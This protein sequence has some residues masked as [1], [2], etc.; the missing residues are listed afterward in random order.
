[1]KTF[2]S[3][4]VAL[5][6]A[7]GV[8]P[9]RAQTPADFQQMAN[10]FRT[11][12][13]AKQSDSLYSLYSPQMATALPPDKTAQLLDQLHIQL[14]ML[15][16]IQLSHQE[17][18]YASYKATFEKTIVTMTLAVDS[19]KHLSGFHFLP[20]QPETPAAP[21]NGES[22]ILQLETST[23][24]L[25]GTLVIPPGHSKLPVVLI[26][27]GSGPTDRDGNSP[28]LGLH[29][30]MYK[31]LADSLSRHGIASLRYDKR[32][33][34]A[35]TAAM[36]SEASLTFASYIDDAVG[37]LA[38]LRADPRFS[39]VIV[40]GHSEGSLV[41]MVASEN[42]KADAYISAAGAGDRIDKVLLPQL[43]V[44]SPPLADSARILFDSLAKGQS[45]HVEQG[46]LLVFFRASI[47]P[48][49]I[50]WLRY[51]PQTEI[52]KLHIPVLII[53]GSTDLQTT[54]GDA[55]KMK[56]AK[57]DATLKIITGMNHIFRQVGADR[58]P[59]IATYNDPSLPL[60]PEVVSDIVAFLLTLH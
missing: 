16:T 53:Q 11:L 27:A 5:L 21:V 13:N 59:N 30:D 26:I 39:K 29:S 23:G 2:L 48:Y 40:L 44:Q 56:A 22:S 41:G 7:A 43:A 14:G 45:V 28:M 6:F 38:L 50:S 52:K 37:Y 35:S 10:R 8:L 49:M 33:V 19:A 20:Y 24:T 3:L 1:M 17:K 57:P 36:S 42:G 32:G 46:P 25:S 15:Q 47:Q 55:E 9:A 18:S 4:L 51:N 58:Q 31:L 54:V 60:Q 12:Y 34:G